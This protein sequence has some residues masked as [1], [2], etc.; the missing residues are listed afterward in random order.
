L[1]LVKHRSASPSRGGRSTAGRRL[2][3]LGA[4]LA[5]PRGQVAGLGAGAGDG[6]DLAVEGAPLEPRERVVQ[7]GHR[8]DQGDGRWAQV[9]LG[10]A[11]GDVRE[12]AGDRLLVGQRAP[13]HD[14]G[15]LVG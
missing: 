8:A 13:G 11:L 9:R 1:G 5:Q 4:Q 3:H 15:R 7:L 2:D 10:R 12:R 6:D 14:R